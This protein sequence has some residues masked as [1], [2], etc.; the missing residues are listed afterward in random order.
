MKGVWRKK[1]S[2]EV[3]GIMTE[4]YHSS[5]WKVAGYIERMHTIC[6]ER[7]M[8]DVKEQQLLDQVVYGLRIE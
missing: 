8:F 5:E 1:W 6:K 4:C 3:N 7:G 2:Q